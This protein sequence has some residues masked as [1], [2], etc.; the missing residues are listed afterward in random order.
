MSAVVVCFVVSSA[1]E[2]AGLPDVPACS[3]WRTRLSSTAFVACQAVGCARFRPRRTSQTKTGS[4]HFQILATSKRM[5]KRHK[6]RPLEDRAAEINRCSKSDVVTSH[7]FVR[8]I[9][10]TSTASTGGVMSLTKK[11]F[12]IRLAAISRTTSVEIVQPFADSLSR[13]A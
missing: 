10:R 1:R 8:S 13:R 9:H 5:V 2:L 6:H 7:G 11:C 12:S 3:K 4:S